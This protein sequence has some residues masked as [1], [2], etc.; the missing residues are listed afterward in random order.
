MTGIHGP[1][2]PTWSEIFKFWSTCSW[3][4]RFYSLDSWWWDSFREFHF[5]NRL[6]G[7]LFYVLR[8]HICNI[9][10]QKIFNFSSNFEQDNINPDSTG[11]WYFI[12]EKKWGRISIIRMLKIKTDFGRPD[13]VF[14]WFRILLK[15]LFLHKSWKITF[16]PHLNWSLK[17]NLVSLLSFGG[18]PIGSSSG[19][20]TFLS[21]PRSEALSRGLRIFRTARARVK[22]RL[23]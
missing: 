8:K 13:F 17:L 7:S 22:N 11:F 2:G 5:E 3:T 23:E 20:K 21:W 15:S 14:S 1:T 6:L 10:D 19:K 18:N 12:K 9:R 4:S 16:R